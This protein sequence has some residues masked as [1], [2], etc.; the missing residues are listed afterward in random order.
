MWPKLAGADQSLEQGP[1]LGQPS[2]VGAR[3]GARL[4]DAMRFV[5]VPIERRPW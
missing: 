1:A 4:V 3:L 2:R 5:G